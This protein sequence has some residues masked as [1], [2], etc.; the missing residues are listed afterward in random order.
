M[1]LLGNWILKSAVSQE[2]TEELSWFFACWYKFG[3]A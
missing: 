1:G 2:R 3:K